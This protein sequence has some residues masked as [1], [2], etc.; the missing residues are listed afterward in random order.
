MNNESD[1]EGQPVLPEQPV[2][3]SKTLLI[4]LAAGLA[5]FVVIVLLL[6]FVRPSNDQANRETVNKTVKIGLL[7]PLSGA[8]VQIGTSA[9]RGIELALREIDKEG[10]TVELVTSDTD[11]SPDKAAGALEQLITEEKVIAVIGDFCSSATL[12]AAPIAEKYGIP[13]VSPAS[14]SPGISEAG[15]HVFRTI[16]SDQLQASFL[17]KLMTDQEHKRIAVI[18]SDEPYGNGLQQAVKANLESMGSRVVASEGVEP[19][20]VDLTPQIQRIK[21]TAPD[22]LLIVINSYASNVAAMVAAQKLGLNIAVYG[23]EAAKSQTI[24]IDAAAAAEGLTVSAVSA[25]DAKFIEK[26]KAVYQMEP[27][28]YSAQSYDAAKAIG[29]T[30]VKG[31]MTGPAIKNALYNVDFVGATGQIKFDSNG[32][33]AGNYL[34]FKVVDGEF[35]PQD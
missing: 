32:D 21:A 4:A 3:T 8:N 9:K 6:V 34:V 25:G 20:A 11:C 16:P 5:V 27:G 10:L 22:A 35:V 33:V 17:A 19:D 26:Y 14:S 30:I 12:A 29:S 18:H 31:A 7:G 15:E 28:D 23:S 24:L 2:K 13:L 1:S